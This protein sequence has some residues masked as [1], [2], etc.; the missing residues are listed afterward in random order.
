MGCAARSKPCTL[1]V[2]RLVLTP[3]DGTNPRA[4]RIGENSIRPS[5]R[6]RLLGWICL[7]CGT[8]VAIAGFLLDSQVTGAVQADTA[9][10]RF[11]NGLFG[12]AVLG[13]MGGVLGLWSLRVGGSGWLPQTATVVALVGLLLWTIGGLYLTTNASADQVFTPAGGLISSIGMIM[14]GIAVI[15]ARVLNDWRKF[16]PLLVGGWFFVQLPLQVI[17]F[18]GVRG[19]P[20]YTI[21]LGVFG[22]LWVL[23]GYVVRSYA[24]EHTGTERTSH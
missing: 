2:G 20:S 1:L 17:F 12:V 4:A 23:V 5:N 19:S 22:V 13:L 11:A 18:I 6:I 3:Q 21:L 7:V 8:L 14:L 16:V 9:I 10:A 15:R 24:S